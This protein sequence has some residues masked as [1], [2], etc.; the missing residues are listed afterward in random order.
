M[1][2]FNGSG[3]SALCARGEASF[4][5]NPD[6]IHI[7]AALRVKGFGKRNPTIKALRKRVVVNAAN[8]RPFRHRMG[9]AIKRKVSAPA[10]VILLL[11][12]GRPSAVVRPVSLRVVDTLQCHALGALA[13]VGNEVGGGFKPAFANRYPAPAVMRE[14]CAIRI[15][16]TLLH[17]K[18]AFIGSGGAPAILASSLAHMRGPLPST[19]CRFASARNDA[20]SPQVLAPYGLKF[21]AITG[22][23]PMTFAGTVN[24]R[25][26]QKAKFQAAHFDE[27]SHSLMMPFNG[28]GIKR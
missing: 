25:H 13:H 2:G 22:A 28:S 24:C 10:P 15:C 17:G 18:P 16:A 20:A 9:H 7:D 3:L 4:N 26:G 5:C 27:F 14:S 21:S 19:P 8:P 23:K 12:S 11:G 6:L 1:A